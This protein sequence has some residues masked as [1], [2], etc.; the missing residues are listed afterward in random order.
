MIQFALG[1]AA[2][3]GVALLVLSLCVRARRANLSASL[4]ATA[5]R[6]L[7]AMPSLLVLPLYLFIAIGTPLSAW[8]TAVVYLASPCASTRGGCGPSL[9]ATQSRSALLACRCRHLL[10]ILCGR[11]GRRMLV[12]C[13]HPSRGRSRI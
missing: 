5:S 9:L 4:L 7:L 8:I 1:W 10:D 6:P 13:T 11:R 3:A 12:R 2:C